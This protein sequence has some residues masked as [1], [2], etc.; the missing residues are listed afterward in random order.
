M[1]NALLL[2]LV[3]ITIGVAATL[4]TF[5]Q[6]TPNAYSDAAQLADAFNSNNKV[7]FYNLL[8]GYTTRQG[9]TASP[10]L[11]RERL[12]QSGNRILIEYADLLEKRVPATLNRA[13]ISLNNGY[14]PEVFFNPTA[15][16]LNGI[17]LDNFADGL[18]KFIIQRIKNEV[19]YNFLLRFQKEFLQH[20]EMK[21][22][23]PSTRDLLSVTDQKSINL[24]LG[25]LRSAFISDLDH[26]PAN[27]P[28][29]A[30]EEKY[31]RIAQ[32]RPALK[33][34]AASAAAVAYL[35]DNRDHPDIVINRLPSFDFIRNSNN[36]G[37][38]RSV[39]MLAFVSN[40]L[41]D[42]PTNPDT[43]INGDQLAQLERIPHATV[44]FIG[45]NYERFGK[46]IAALPIGG[47]TNAFNE[48]PDTDLRDTDLPPPVITDDGY[49]EFETPA[50]PSRAGTTPATPRKRGGLDTFFTQATSNGSTPTVSDFIQS[51][52][53]NYNP[54]TLQAY[55]DTATNAP[56]LLFKPYFDQFIQLGGHL[57]ATLTNAKSS[58]RSNMQTAPYEVVSPYLATFLDVLGYAFINQYFGSPETYNAYRTIA[59]ALLNLRQSVTERQ[60][61][62]AIIYTSVLLGNALPDDI[63]AKQDMLKYGM[64]IANVAAAQNPTE[65]QLAIETVALPTG[66]SAVKQQSAFNI[67]F[68]A[69]AG[70]FLG[71][72]KL[73]QPATGAQNSWRGTGGLVAP[74]GIAFSKGLDRIGSAT[75]FASFI[76]VGALVS[77]RFKDNNAALLPEFKLQNVLA[78]GLYGIYGLPNLPISLGV[79]VQYG[80]QLRKLTATN[81]STSTSAAYRVNAF[82][83]VDIPVFNLYNV[84]K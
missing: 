73:L 31:K 70:G 6:N 41:K 62:A 75:L 60:Y 67:S 46:S 11:V 57:N 76:D 28:K 25:V 51:F 68:N 23:F 52:R 47:N 48:S 61:G 13:P 49:L 63:A 74:F 8:A 45:L 58:S 16:M 77:F 79:G 14:V 35:V 66:S 9:E 18:S 2:I 84:P 26:L 21:L 39:N 38:K 20:D 69:Y 78:P 3:G 19:S 33:T 29:L 44:L 30:N 43:W 80:P 82:I 71:G 4:P 54:S 10:E 42:V 65:V 17:G 55:T 24:M 81:L 50:S 56:Y 27:L 83:A 15:P 1:K 36:A 59:P 12:R 5:A 37:I 32:R 64:F 7:A 53:L 40:S 72:E 22:L 34:L